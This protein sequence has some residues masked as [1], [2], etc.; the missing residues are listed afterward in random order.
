[1]AHFSTFLHQSL[2]KIYKNTEKGNFNQHL[3]WAA[4][5]RWSKYT[6]GFVAFQI[7]I[8]IDSPEDDVADLRVDDIPEQPPDQRHNSSNQEQQCNSLSPIQQLQHNSLC[9]NQEQQS[10]SLSP[11][12]EREQNEDVASN[13]ES[14]QQQRL[15]HTKRL[16]KEIVKLER[17][18]HDMAANA[19]KMEKVRQ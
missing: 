16:K 19:I 1:M 14:F 18:E 7:S 5:K 6:T 8:P 12:P 2:A 17:L 15:V 4:P 3:E 13:L 11:E 9:D 10:N